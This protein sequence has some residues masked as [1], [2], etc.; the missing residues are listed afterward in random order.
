MGTL[1]SLGLWNGSSSEVGARNIDCGERITARSI[2]FCNSR[3]F[4]GHWYRT[5]ASIVAGGIMSI[6]LFMR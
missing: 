6:R 1:G 5:N 4:P 3:T 2:K